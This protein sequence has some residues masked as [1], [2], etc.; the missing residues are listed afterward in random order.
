MIVQA[1]F[2]ALDRPCRRR[3]KPGCPVCLNESSG[4]RPIPRVDGGQI[5]VFQSPARHGSVLAGP[6]PEGRRGTKPRAGHKLLWQRIGEPLS[7]VSTF[8]FQA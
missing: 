4:P 8:S 3:W 7:T 1:V 5:A 6:F 2:W